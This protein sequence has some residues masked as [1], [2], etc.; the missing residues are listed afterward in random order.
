MTDEH[1]QNEQ[2][3]ADGAVDTEPNA[4]L[5]GIVESLSADEEPSSAEEAPA[6]EEPAAEPEAEVAES[7]E[8]PVAEETP[9]AD[10]TPAEEPI[11]LPSK[12]KSPVPW[13]PYWCLSGAWLA[14]CVAAAY[15]LTRDPNMPSLR[16]DAYTFVVAGGLVLTVAGPVLGL[17]VWSTVRSNLSKELRAGLFVSSFIRAAVITFVGVVAWTG[18]LILVDSLRLGLIRF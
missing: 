3:A 1:E 6:T 2:S 11:E 17:V 16:Q 5:E 18:T 7:A 10:E 13:W 8:A 14:L 4:E 12:P 9:A 15:F